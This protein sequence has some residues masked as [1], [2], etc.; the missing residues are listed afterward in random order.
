MAKAPAKAKEEIKFR[1]VYMLDTV[2]SKDPNMIKVVYVQDKE[3]EEGKSV[4]CFPKREIERNGY[5]QGTWGRNVADHKN[6]VAIW[7]L[8][9]CGE[10]A[11]KHEGY[12]SGYRE[13]EQTWIDFLANQE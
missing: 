5:F 3:L 2:F 9:Q 1:A 6:T 7:A 10:E 12:A 11:E 8:T 4:R 13:A